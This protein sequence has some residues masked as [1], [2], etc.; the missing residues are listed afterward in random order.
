V[1]QAYLAVAVAEHAARA[2]QLVLNDT[3]HLAIRGCRQAAM[4]SWQLEGQKRGR[5]RGIKARIK[6]ADQSF[7]KNFHADC[8]FIAAPFVV[9]AGAAE[10]ACGRSPSIRFSPDFSPDFSQGDS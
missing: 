4:K 6:S 2:W 1:A 8:R 9:I 7:H 10:I 5:Q 3:R